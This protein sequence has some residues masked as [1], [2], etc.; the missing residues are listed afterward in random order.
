MPMVWT[1]L[2]SLMRNG[3]RQRT[4]QRSQRDAHRA[5][6]PQHRTARCGGMC[7]GDDDG[8]YTGWP[9][10][11]S[12]PYY[13]LKAL[14]DQDDSDVPSRRRASQTT[15]RSRRPPS[16]ACHPPVRW[17]R[18]TMSQSRHRTSLGVTGCRGK[19][20]AKDRD[21][22]A[23]MS[24]ARCRKH[25]EMSRDVV[26]CRARSLEFTKRQQSRRLRF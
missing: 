22:V 23:R 1:A 5:V 25:V 4:G 10:L 20:I 2:V 13:Q 18:R 14:I 16:T 17:D 24:R 15:S 6:C 11:P 8:G 12:F 9:F 26:A 19:E 3:R 21:N 7:K